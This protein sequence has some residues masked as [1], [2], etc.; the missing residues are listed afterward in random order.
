MAHGLVDI[1]NLYHVPQHPS[2]YIF[3]ALCLIYHKHPKLWPFRMPI[4]KIRN[5]KQY[6]LLILLDLVILAMETAQNE[7]NIVKYSYGITPSLMIQHS[8]SFNERD[9]RN[10]LFWIIWTAYTQM[11]INLDY[12]LIMSLDNS[13]PIKRTAS[14]Q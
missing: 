1:S 10:H 3:L 2:T 8:L 9:N 14:P 7:H 11:T 12:C 13:Q 4:L 5:H 6:I